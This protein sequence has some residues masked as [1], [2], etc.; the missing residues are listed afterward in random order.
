MEGSRHHTK[1]FLDLH[2]DFVN[3]LLDLRG[4]FLLGL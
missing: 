2:I 4:A 3:A 1:P